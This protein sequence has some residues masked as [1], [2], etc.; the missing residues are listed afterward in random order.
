M[1]EVAGRV[2]M[3]FGTVVYP[4]F[5]CLTV[6]GKTVDKVGSIFN[7]STYKIQMDASDQEMLLTSD[8]N[9]NA[10][11]QPGDQ[12]MEMQSGTVI[13]GETSKVKCS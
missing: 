4:L 3:A 13:C 1:V 6:V 5:L 11:V 2:G 8:N 9:C 12:K 10:K 7:S